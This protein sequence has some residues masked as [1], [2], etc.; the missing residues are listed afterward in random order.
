M[1][2]V[3]FEDGHSVR[4][5]VTRVHRDVRRESRNVQ[6]S[7]GRQVRLKH[8]LRH[9]PSVSLGVQKEFREKNWMFFRRN[10]EFV[11]Q[12][13]IPDFLCVVPIRDD[14]VLD[15][16]AQKRNPALGWRRPRSQPQKSAPRSTRSRKT[17][18]T[19]I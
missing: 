8:G 9:A 19:Y 17:G 18:S 5:A 3:T 2:S 13:V 11:V 12:R 6:D 16:D 1:Q 10:P 7:P 14:T 4:H 15:I